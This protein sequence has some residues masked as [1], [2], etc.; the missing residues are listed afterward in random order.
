MKFGHLIKYNVRNIFI[1]KV[2]KNGVK[3][4]FLDPFLND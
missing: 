2:A 4:L 3:K 1:E